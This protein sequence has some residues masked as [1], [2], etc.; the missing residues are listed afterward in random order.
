MDGKNPAPVDRWFIVPSLSHY[1][2]CF[3]VPV[4]CLGKC[5]LSVRP[6]IMVKC[7]DHGYADLPACVRDVSI[8]ARALSMAWKGPVQIDFW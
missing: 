2:Q 3:T 5:S 8:V 4:L 1:L 7:I 6:T